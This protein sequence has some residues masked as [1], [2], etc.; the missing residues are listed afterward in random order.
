MSEMAVAQ[1]ANKVAIE[2]TDE[3][4]EVFLKKLFVQ[5]QERNTG[6]GT[7]ALADL[8]SKSHMKGAIKV[9]L[10]DLRVPGN[11]YT[12]PED[13]TAVSRF[14]VKNGVQIV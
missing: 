14:L 10:A 5:P 11:F 2:T 3:N 13:V 8:V 9:R 4:G 12:H 7:K 1:P 6:L